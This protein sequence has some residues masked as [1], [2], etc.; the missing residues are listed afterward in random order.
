MAP[1]AN[2]AQ[3]LP[4]PETLRSWRLPSPVRLMLR[5]ARRKPL[6]AIGG[7]IVLA[8]L[9]MA[10]FADRLA[11]YPYDASIAGARMKPP[12]VQFW[13]GT[14]NLARDVWSRVVYGAR[15]SI[16]VGFATVTLATLMA[17]TVG[18]SSAYLGGAY[19]TLVQ[20]VVDAW[21]SFPALVVVL[22]LMSALGPGL[23]NLI[24]ALSILGAAAAS[25]VIRGATLS[26]I[27]N[28]YIE[29]AKAIGA[30]HGRVI[31]CYVLPNVTA[32][33]LILAT[34]GLGT[35]ILAESALSFLGFGIP[36]PYPSWG[37]MLSGSGRSFMYYAPWMALFPGA[38][39]T[40]AVFGFN[41]LGDALRDV[42]DPRLR[43]GGGGVQS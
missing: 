43:G 31:L 15:I 41:M 6:G 3:T 16:T 38:A 39:I 29:G 28:P 34:I 42:L 8:L 12:S 4:L 11:P 20:R 7:T 2:S 14:D 18:V 19:D 13:M 40:L 23:S 35:V 32:T 37:G 36:P 1:M 21:M 5:F 9:V 33:I 24:L 30:G 10:A 26:V 27:A 17:T 25:R 22:S